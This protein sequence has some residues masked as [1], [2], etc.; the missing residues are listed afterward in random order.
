MVEGDTGFLNA[1]IPKRNEGFIKT[2]DNSI[3]RYQSE[4]HHSSK[5]STCNQNHLHLCYMKNLLHLEELAMFGLSIWLFSHT[6]FS[7]WWFPAL[8]LAPDLGMIGYAF[9]PK[10]GA[11]IYSLF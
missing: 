6:A 1:L 5:I 11:I 2:E 3:F 10:A 8:I 7:W 4:A 9:G